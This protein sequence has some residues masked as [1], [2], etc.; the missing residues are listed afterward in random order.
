MKGAGMSPDEFADALLN[1]PS[2]EFPRV[3][4]DG[5]WVAWS[6]YRVGPAADVYVAPTDGSAGSVQLTDT[7]DDTVLVSWLPD[8]MA[9][10]VTQD[11]RGNERDQL[12][13]VDLSQPGVMQPLTEPNPNYYLRGGQLHPDNRRLVYAANFVVASG[14]EIEPTWVYCHDLQTG[15][16]VPLARPAEACYYEPRLSPAGSHVLYTR[17]ERHPAGRQLWLVDMEGREDREIVNVG[18]DKKAFASWFPD[19]RRVLILAETETHQR[20][21][22]W[23][24]GAPANAVRW[25][26]DDPERNIEEAYVP[27]G[28]Q[29]V[30]IV[31]QR[32]ARARPALL[33]PET[34]QEIPLPVVRG[35]LVPLAPA[36]SGRWVAR[37]YSSQ[38]PDDLVLCDLADP[39]PE[40]FV[41]LTRVWER[42]SI[43]PADLAPAEDF[44]WRSVDGL[45]VQGW[46]YRPRG[47]ARGTIVY[48]HGGPTWHSQEWVNAEVQ[49]LA[50]RGFNVL[51]VN[52]RGSTG[53]DRAYKE[54]IKV[55]GWG[56]REQQDIRTGIEAL[57]AAGIARSGQV[58]VTGTSYGGYSA[59]YV[60]THFP[61]E[62]V[63]AA[64]PICGMT[65][66]VVDYETTRPDLRPYS[67]EMMGGTPEQ[68]PERYFERSP[69]NFVANIWG[70]LLIVQGLRD[71][72]VTPENVRTVRAALEQRG[73]PYELLTFDDEGHGIARPKNQRTLYL[74]LAEFFGRAF[75]QPTA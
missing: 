64:A 59:W 17:K 74:R 69:I 33:D 53:F 38:Q 30:V 25:L 39:R 35:G 2:L 6:W 1:L 5:R 23:E 18:A 7:S 63:A 65:D 26:L 24:L 21:G 15:E 32:E 67:E 10:L 47:E 14:N 3:S 58:G 57:L 73:I 50:S 11:R 9:V 20:V 60:I 44:R 46:L 56:G 31:E 48:V 16:R 68:V 41:S 13:R 45:A 4:P 70:K 19:G 8:S 29:S 55:D 37:F 75:A 54:A 62:I 49:F 43:T 36:A 42:T 51:D 28:S 72:N 66:L 34:G 27:Y 61:P 40:T 71:P 52:Y 22:V 12:F